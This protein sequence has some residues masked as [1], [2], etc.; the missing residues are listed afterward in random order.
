LDSKTPTFTIYEMNMRI[1][2]G[3]A[4]VCGL[5]PV[6]LAPFSVHAEE[7][8]QVSAEQVDK[9]I[10]AIEQLA[11]KEIQENAVPGLA[12]AVVFQDKV[13]YAKGFGVRDVK[14]KAPVDDIAIV[15][16]DG[17]LA[18]VQG[19]RNKTF[20]MKHYDRDTFT[21]QTEGEN[22]VGTS[23]VTFTIGADAIATQV[24]VE[25][26]NVRGEGTFNRVPGK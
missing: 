16:K 23:G 8:S 9:A 6:L 21:Y 15:E 2:R 7:K 3:V 4:L 12:I 24:F 18:I 20:P 13:M 19:P 1:V 17:G 10:R 5:V 14:T 22:A 11:Q 25:N 26:L